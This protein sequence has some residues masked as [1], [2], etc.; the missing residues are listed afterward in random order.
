MKN[1]LE[2]ACKWAE[3]NVDKAKT[4]IGDKAEPLKIEWEIAKKKAAFEKLLLEY[5]KLCYYEA[6]EEEQTKCHS[7]LIELESE[8]GVLE[9]DVAKI[10]EDSAKKAEEKVAEKATVYCTKCGAGYKNKEQFCSK[11]GSKLNK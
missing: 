10:K 3:E 1:F 7:A 9:A 4:F 5:G 8:I 6:P 2:N 11:C